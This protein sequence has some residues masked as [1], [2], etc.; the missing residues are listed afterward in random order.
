M[1]L[2]LHPPDFYLQVARIADTSHWCPHLQHFYGNNTKLPSV[3]H[4]HTHCDFYLE[5]HYYRESSQGN[6]FFKDKISLCSMA[7]LELLV[8]EGDL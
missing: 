2:N 7:G 3:S 4:L 6:G 5:Y 8:V 1:T